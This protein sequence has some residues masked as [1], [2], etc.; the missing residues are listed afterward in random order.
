MAQE[1][2]SVGTYV[3]YAL[4]TPNQTAPGLIHYA[5][6]MAEKSYLHGS[7]CSP[8]TVSMRLNEPS[9]P[10]HPTIVTAA[11]APGLYGGAAMM[12]GLATL[13]G[14]AAM[15]GIW[16]VSAAPAA[17]AGEALNMLLVD[18]NDDVTKTGTE[19]ATRCTSVVAASASAAAVPVVGGSLS[20]AGLT[21]G[22]A[23]IG[24]L[25]GGG[26]A[27]GILLCVALPVVAVGVVGGVVAL[28]LKDTRQDQL[29]GQYRAFVHDWRNKERYSGP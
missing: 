9:E 27:M 26:M 16:L 13:G 17:A 19:I 8:T 21:S 25:L 28:T 14:G 15:G 10:L 6:I 5:E 18:D 24:S 11:A 3:V 20:A 22:L 1:P 7:A 23:G 12:N 29:K 2:L 4:A